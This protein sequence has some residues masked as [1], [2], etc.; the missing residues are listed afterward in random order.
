M[1]TKGLIAAVPTAFQEDGSVDLQAIGPMAGHVGQIGCAGVFV[2]GTT[3][4]SMSLTVEE[5][6]Q[7]LVE[8]RRVW[9]EDRLLFAHVG[10]NS[11]E[12]AK[13]LARHARETGVDAVAAIAPSFFKPAGI[14]G[15]VQWC[16]QVAASVPDVPFYFYHMP[17]LTGSAFSVARFLEQSAPRI[18]NL[19]GVKY[20]HETLGDYMESLRL[21]NKRFDMLWGRDE[22]LLAAWAMGARAATGSTFSLAAPLYLELMVAFERGDMAAAREAQARAISMINALAAT[23]NFFAALK[24][25]LRDQGLPIRPDTRR[26]LTPVCKEA[27]AACRKAV[28]RLIGAGSCKTS[29]A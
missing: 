20:T 12:D 9:P 7:T 11:L 16:E 4:E 10:H 5:R 14:E 24:Q 29:F 3:G 25:A 19:A 21:E 15:M 2:N 1:R 23:G 8:W 28:N 26:P 18:P 6:E 27:M 22:M 13:R 17:A